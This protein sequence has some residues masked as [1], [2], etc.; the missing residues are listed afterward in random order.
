MKYIFE[1][2]NCTAKKST[3]SS[4]EAMGFSLVNYYL[5]KIIYHLIKF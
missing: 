5:S 2:K 3:K 4:L 1:I